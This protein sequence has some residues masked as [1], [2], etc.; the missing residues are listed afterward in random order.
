MRRDPVPAEQKL[1]KCLRDRQL[2]GFKF[3]RQYVADFYCH[4]CRLIVEIDGGT[5]E[6]REKY[7]STKE[8][9]Y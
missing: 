9:K 6:R 4:E 8:Q 5:H 2:G 7:D 1:W 3:R